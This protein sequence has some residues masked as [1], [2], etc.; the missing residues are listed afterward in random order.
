MFKLRRDLI[1]FIG[2]LNS[3]SNY[4]LFGLFAS[5]S[6]IEMIYEYNFGFSYRPTH[7]LQR[8]FTSAKPSL[9]LI[10]YLSIHFCLDILDR[11]VTMYL[12]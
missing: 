7:I 1:I 9:Q 12:L 8:V 4:V 3:H 10:H 5:T 6:T 11:N 2:T